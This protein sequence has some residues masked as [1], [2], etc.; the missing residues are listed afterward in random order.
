MHRRIWLLVGAVIAVLGVATSATATSKTAASSKS[1]KLAAAPFAQAWANV[2]R[3][4]AARRAKSSAVVAMEQDLSGTWNTAEADSNLAWANWAGIN[5]VLRAPY[6][7]TNKL[8]Y[9][10]DLATKVVINK[11]SI[12]Y[13]IRNNAF[14]NWGGKKLP[15]TYKDFVYTWKAITNPKNNPASRQGLNQV[16]RFTHKGLKQVTFYWKTKGCTADAPCGP[17]ADYRDLFSFIY[18]SAALAKMSDSWNTMWA[19]C[20]CGS[21]GKPVSDG[22]YL[23]TNYTKGQGLTLKTNPMWYG[24]KPSLKEINFKVITDTNSEVQ[25]I[26][27]GEVDIAYP[28]PSTALTSLRSD[29][30]INYKVAPGLY[31][32]HI[33]LE[34]G[35][36]ASN[37]LLR[38]P[39]MRQALMLGMDRQGLV[40]AI[41]KGVADGLKPLDNITLFQSDN[42]YKADFGKWNFN[43]QKALDILKKH[44]T[45]GPSSVTPGNTNYF[46]CAGFPAK[47]KYTT[48]AGNSRRETSEAIFKAGLASIGIQLVDD[49]QPASVMFGDTVLTAGNFD[50]IEFAYGG[51]IDPGGFG[52]IWGC[53]G[54]QNYIA[55]CNRKAT[56]F[57][58]DAKT[59]LDAKKRN[60]D[61]INADKLM[62][63][64]VPAIPL[65]ALPDVL[66]YNKG[67]HNITDNAGSGFTWDIEQWKWS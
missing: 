33:E 21:D 53:K 60:A 1:A 26:R 51:T 5:P 41:F 27:G 13:T 32:E 66:T 40:N 35:P 15:V 62:S 67:L 42:R 6:V 36:K 52:P 57:F 61:F 20:I 37:P 64:D 18:P 47:F 23:L 29:S 8:T 30:S 45:G 59:Q 11:K 34:F 24:H 31:L 14:W 63:N 16:A 25:A 58:D 43:P 19:N 39:W 46:T 3:T 54:S 55:Y 56:N 12:T 7:V 22:P 10:P 4:P 2:P 44:C 9:V 28:Q 65:Y 17:F 49:F 38:S 50:M 48:T